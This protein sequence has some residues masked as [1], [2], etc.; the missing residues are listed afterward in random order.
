MKRVLL[1]A[2]FVLSSAESYSR[3]INKVLEACNQ[4]DI[5]LIEDPAQADMVSY[6]CD[7]IFNTLSFSDL[8]NQE[9][10]SNDIQ[11]MTDGGSDTGGGA[12]RPVSRPGKRK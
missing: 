5:E 7:I 12:A 8:E 4:T 3:E 2:I 9:V 6:A 10:Q 11:F 1:L